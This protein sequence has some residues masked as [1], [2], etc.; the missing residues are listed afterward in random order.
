MQIIRPLR[1]YPT[2]S[3]TNYRINIWSTAGPKYAGSLPIS[4]SR[5]TQILNGVLISLRPSAELK[6]AIYTPMEKAE[7]SA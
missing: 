3:M 1:V 4:P 5:K 2:L 7:R 6:P